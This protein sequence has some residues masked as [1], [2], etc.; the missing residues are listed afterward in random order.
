MVAQRRLHTP[1]GVYSGGAQACARRHHAQAID[2]PASD[3][4]DDAYMRGQ[5]VRVR[6]VEAVLHCQQAGQPRRCVA[7]PR[8]P[9]LPARP[10][11]H[12]VRVRRRP[13]RSRRLWEQLVLLHALREGRLDFLADS[14]RHEAIDTLGRLL[15]GVGAALGEELADVIDRSG[16]L[17]GD[18]KARLRG[19]IAAELPEAT[20][21]AFF[22]SYDK[23]TWQADGG[24]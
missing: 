7:I 6:S 16:Q 24:A 13:P 4:D 23:S 8:V 22:V 19:A 12:A 20:G 1:S 10:S 11:T 17:E 3:D 5:R 21:R 18:A 2:L 15:E 9:G 14:S